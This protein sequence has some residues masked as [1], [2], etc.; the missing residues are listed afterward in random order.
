[1]RKSKRRRKTNIEVRGPLFCYYCDHPVKE[2][3]DNFPQH[4]TISLDHVIPK[5]KGGKNHS[6]N[7][8]V[9]CF[10]CDTTKANGDAGRFAKA[11]KKYGRPGDH[12]LEKGALK[13]W[14]ERAG[15][16]LE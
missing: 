4:D 11:V 9:A 15:Y 16:F 13:E 14:R 8:V 1:M 3:I 6:D 12:W 10:S 2:R 7:R 5:S